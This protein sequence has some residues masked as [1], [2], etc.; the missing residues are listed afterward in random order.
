V[1]LTPPFVAALPRLA[2]QARQAGVV[3]IERTIVERV[4]KGD[5][6][7]YRRL[8]ERHQR[9]VHAIVYRMVGSAAD[10]DDLA[11][12]A[13]VAAFDALAD[14]DPA[15]PFAAWINR[16]A[17]NLA[18]DHLKSKKRTEVA[19]PDGLAATAAW[20]TTPEPDPE[21]AAQAGEQREVLARALAELSG[22]DREVLVLKD[23]AELSY[24]EIRGVTGRPITALK[25]RVLRARQKLRAVL[26]RWGG[27]R[28]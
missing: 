27:A 21:S 22:K 1:S 5:I 14:F 6:E 10:A 11:Q 25:I 4:Q 3:A 19:L 18:K 12:Q 7:A 15:L 24:E 9:R 2:A 28:G 16:I 20:L 26:E 17:V 23:V 8:V 13:F